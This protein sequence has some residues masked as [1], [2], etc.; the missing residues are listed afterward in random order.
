LRLS[1]FS[2]LRRVFQSPK[3]GHSMLYLYSSST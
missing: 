3:K 2:L 1:N